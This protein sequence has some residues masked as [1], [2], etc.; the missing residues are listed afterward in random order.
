MKLIKKGLI[1]YS[2]SRNKKD[3]SPIQTNSWIVKKGERLNDSR[4]EA[5]GGY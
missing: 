2:S 5:D 3:R 1:Q 4:R